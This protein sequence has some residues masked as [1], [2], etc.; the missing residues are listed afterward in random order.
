MTPHA[1]RRIK[2]I[3]RMLLDMRLVSASRLFHGNW[4]LA[5]NPDVAKAGINP[6]GHYLRHGGFE[7]RDPNPHF[8]SDWYLA[9][10]PDVG[11]SGVNPL[12]HYLRSGAAEGRN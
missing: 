2:S 12:V 5:Q 7:G 11:K 3:P 10:N 1:L 8:D 6:I 4:Y 9:N